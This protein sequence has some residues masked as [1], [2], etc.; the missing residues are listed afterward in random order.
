MG[1]CPRPPSL[2]TM[3]V[4]PISMSK[5]DWP[6][7]VKVCQET[8]GFS[9]T[10]GLDMQGIKADSPAAF[11]AT[12]D[13]DNNPKRQL[14]IP[15]PSYHH[16]HF[17]FIIIDEDDVLISFR[18]NTTIRCIVRPFGRREAIC[19]ATDSIFEW[20]ATLAFQLMQIDDE[21]VIAILNRIYDILCSTELRG[22]FAD[23][24]KVSIGNS[25]LFRLRKI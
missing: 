1:R 11:L 15:S 5:V 18:A 8:I 2:S 16:A 14:S 20:Y 23:Y 13:W 12:L 25:P 7:Y 6:A 10:R 24:K 4:I 17:G 19:L 22:M 3:Q 9:P 21:K